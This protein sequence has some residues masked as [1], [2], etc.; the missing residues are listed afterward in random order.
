MAM[1]ETAVN[2]I[3]NL[4]RDMLMERLAHELP[5][6]SGEMGTTPTGIAWRSGMEEDR[7]RLMVSGKRKMKWSE[8]MGLLFVLLGDEKGNEMVEELGLFPDE[9]KKAMSV[10]RNGHEA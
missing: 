8:Y 1:Y 7:I 3:D 9:L 4:D 10:N 2:D 6:I 5:V